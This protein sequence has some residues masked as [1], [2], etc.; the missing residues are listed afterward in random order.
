MTVRDISME[1]DCRVLL[2]GRTHV[3]IIYKQVNES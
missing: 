1:V 3:L 2:V